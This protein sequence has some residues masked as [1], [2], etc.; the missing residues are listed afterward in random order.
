MYIKIRN[1]SGWIAGIEPTPS[2]PQ[3]DALPLNYIHINQY[4][5]T[6]KNI[7][8]KIKEKTKLQK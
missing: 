4:S 2:V 6:I 3:T 1:N 5:K 7:K 8:K